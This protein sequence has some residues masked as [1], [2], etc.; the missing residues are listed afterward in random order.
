[1]LAATA[2]S[3]EK[4]AVKDPIK[5][6]LG[7]VAQTISQGSSPRTIKTANS[8]PHNRNQRLPLG[9]MVFRTSALMTA[10]SILE[11]IS[12]KERPRIMSMML[13]M[14]KKR[15]FLQIL[16]HAKMRPAEDK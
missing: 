9:D 15:S 5:P 1:M 12:N 11:T 16:T 4:V 8:I 14:S 6:R 10:L 3:L 13:K 7:L 2:G